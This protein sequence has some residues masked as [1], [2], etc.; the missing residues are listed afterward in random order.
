MLTTLSK[1]R[2]SFTLT[3]PGIEAV[4]SDELRVGDLIRKDMGDGTQLW[5]IVASKAASATSRFPLSGMT[6]SPTC[7][8]GR[9]LTHPALAQPIPPKIDVSSYARQPDFAPAGSGTCEGRFRDVL[10]RA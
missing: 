3:A 10:E 7:W 8:G 1:E 5:R 2:L 9:Q 4:N 6:C